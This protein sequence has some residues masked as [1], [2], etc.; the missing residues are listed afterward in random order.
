MGC[1]NCEDLYTGTFHEGHWPAERNLGLAPVM[2][3][4]SNNYSTFAAQ[5]QDQYV[6]Y[7]SGAG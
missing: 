4:A 5:L 7:F 2:N 1:V 3:I 6:D